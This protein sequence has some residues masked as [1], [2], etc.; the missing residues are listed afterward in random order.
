MSPV[1]IPATPPATLNSNKA[2]YQL[3]TFAP[4]RESIV[5]VG[6]E[7]SLPITE[8]TP[9]R[10]EKVTDPRIWDLTLSQL[11]E[12]KPCTRNSLEHICA[13]PDPNLSLVTVDESADIPAALISW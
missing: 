3:P 1:D 6:D 11:S 10:T 5:N 2:S 12:A 8:V 13:F 9:K 7:A 4:D